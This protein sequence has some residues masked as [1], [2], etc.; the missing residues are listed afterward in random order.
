MRTLTRPAAAL[1]AALVLASGTSGCAD[2]PNPCGTGASSEEGRLVREVLSV[3]EYE[4]RVGTS[5]RALADA[6]ADGLR[7]LGPDL[8]FFSSRG[9]TYLRQTIPGY[10]ILS[11]EAGWTLQGPGGP[12]GPDEVLYE[13]HGAHGRADSRAATLYAA[14]VLPGELAGRSREVWFTAGTSYAFDPPRAE[15]DQA[16]KDGRMTLTYLLARRVTDALGCENQ[17]LAKPPVLEPLPAPAR[18]DA[19]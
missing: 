14:C 1:L 19:P 8:G 5:T 17:P 2:D 9:C 18:A 6:M 16:A 10:E 4:T 7:S 12:P 3:E 13:L 15:P 11:F